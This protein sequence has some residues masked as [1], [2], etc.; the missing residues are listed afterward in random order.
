MATMVIL[1]IVIHRYVEWS[2]HNPEQGVYNWKGIADLE[3]FL[4]LAQQLGFYVI[5][6]PGPYICAERDNVIS[7]TRPLLFL[8]LRYETYI[9]Y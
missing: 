6:R 1:A 8:H 4:G 3:H 7:N 2:L 9:Y 5:L